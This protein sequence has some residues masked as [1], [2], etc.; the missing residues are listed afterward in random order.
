M[1]TA[2]AHC[3]LL[4]VLPLIHALHTTCMPHTAELLQHAGIRSRFW[5]RCDS[6]V[7]S[8][9]LRAAHPLV[10]ACLMAASQVVQLAQL[11]CSWSCRAALPAVN[12]YQGD[13]THSSS[14]RHVA[15]LCS[16][17]CMRAC[18]PHCAAYDL[19]AARLGQLARRPAGVLVSAQDGQQ[20]QDVH[21]GPHALQ[22]FTNSQ[23][24]VLPTHA[25]LACSWL[26]ALQ[27][28]YRAGRLWHAR[29]CA[30]VR[31]VAGL[32]AA[33]LAVRVKGSTAQRSQHASITAGAARVQ[34]TQRHAATSAACTQPRVTAGVADQ[35]AQQLQHL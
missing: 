14:W 18:V 31:C 2:A 7:P 1:Q 3:C 34:H 26:R 9:M 17:A 5:M 24:H 8:S 33:Q 4:P 27:H 28:L 35:L 23:S 12:T 19:C 13:C 21:A 30:R 15:E 25:P 29:L 10:S 32:Y 22:P 11:L 20:Q 6:H 16:A